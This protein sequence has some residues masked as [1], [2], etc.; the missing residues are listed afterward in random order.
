VDPALVPAPAGPAERVAERHPSHPFLLA[1]G[2][3]LTALA[4]FTLVLT[5]AGLVLVHWLTPGSLGGWEQSTERWFY[6]ERRPI[7][8]H[9][10]SAGT[11]VGST[12]TII[13]AAA[14]VGL[15]FLLRKRFTDFG[16]VVLALPLEA[17]VFGI[18][19]FFVERDRPSI[20]KLEQVAPTS[21]FPSGH[22]AATIAL[23]GSLAL[24]VWARTHRPWLRGAVW[25]VAG[26]LA[27]WC[28]WSRLYRGAH[29]PTDLMA[30]FLL[31]IACIA[32]GTFIVR[33]VV[34]AQRARR[35][36]LREQGLRGHETLVRGAR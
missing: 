24:I 11:F 36:G 28:A 10:A 30:S 23:Y 18:T 27:L 32:M 34:A 25:V 14:V 22:F 9:L 35:Q 2:M 20:P 13:G 21:S 3:W 16:L 26:V 17:S 8:N 4:A 1:V 6:V 31:G 12:A 7:L 19:Q 29:H 33:T 5:A 15:V